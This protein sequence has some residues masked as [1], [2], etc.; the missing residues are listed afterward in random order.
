M[1]KNVLRDFFAHEGIPL[2]KKADT[3]ERLFLQAIE[4]MKAHP[5]HYVRLKNR[6]NDAVK[7]RAINW[8]P[9]HP[10]EHFIFQT[11]KAQL[12]ELP[13]PMV[14]PS[15]PR[16]KA[17]KPVSTDSSGD[18]NIVDRSLSIQ[19]PDS[20]AP[21]PSSESEPDIMLHLPP[22]SAPVN[23]PRASMPVPTRFSHS[24]PIRNPRSSV[25]PILSLRNMT[26]DYVRSAVK[27][28]ASTR[29][30]GA[31][32]TRANHV[33]NV[34]IRQEE[35]DQDDEEESDESSDIPRPSQIPADRL[36]GAGLVSTAM[37]SLRNSIFSSQQEF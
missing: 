33:R 7:V 29:V 15:P 12:R 28:T 3:K 32:A 4:L 27:P 5:I 31:A 8:N 16:A 25:A 34:Q 14:P 1:T 11:N 30:R 6:F 10:T 9:S 37:R 19:P 13:P 20:R 18:A 22:A 21:S 26:Q 35:S 23:G 24:Q 36:A 17:I 2:G